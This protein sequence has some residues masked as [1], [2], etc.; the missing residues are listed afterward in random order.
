MSQYKPTVVE[1]TARIDDQ[2]YQG[3]TPALIEV[4]SVTVAVVGKATGALS[5]MESLLETTLT[6]R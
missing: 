3:T 1:V 5:A 2:M 4:K 6:I